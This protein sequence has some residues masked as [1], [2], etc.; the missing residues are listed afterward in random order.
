ML[1]SNAQQD[2][3]AAFAKGMTAF[4]SRSLTEAVGSFETAAAA[5]PNNA[6]YQY[7]LA[8]ALYD[9]NGAEVAS[10]ALQRAVALEQR[11]PIENWGKRME[12]IQGRS[13]AW[14]EAARREAGLVR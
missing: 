11:E 4:R 7:H 6:I 8:L 5:E 14:I 3:S 9:L 12:R 2:G 13:R 1:I 10:D